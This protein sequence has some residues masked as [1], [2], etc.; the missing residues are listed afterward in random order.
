MLE[1][2]LIALLVF[3]IVRTSVMDYIQ[4]KKIRKCKRQIEGIKKQK[5]GDKNALGAISE[6][7]CVAIEQI[8]QQLESIGCCW[9]CPLYQD[10]CKEDES[11]DLRQHK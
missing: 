9:K 4:N 11:Q 2:M 1:K 3:D 10:K 5:F 7:E 6:L 8:A